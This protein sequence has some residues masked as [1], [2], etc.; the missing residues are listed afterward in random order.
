[1][2]NKSKQ[3]LYLLA[4]VYFCF[5]AMF[6]NVTFL[7]S[8]NLALHVGQHCTLIF[9]TAADIVAVITQL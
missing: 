3:P 5:L 1:M 4:Q 9:A 2:E 7:I 8:E 6:S